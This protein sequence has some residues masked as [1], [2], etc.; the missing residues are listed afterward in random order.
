MKRRNFI[1][2]TAV[3][4][5][6]LM[7]NPLNALAFNNDFPV[8]RPALEKR[9]FTSKAIEDAISK[10][11]FSVKDA[12]QGWLF[13][14]CFPNTLDTTV[15]HKIIDGKPD[16]YV[17]TGDIDAMW[18]RDSC[19]QVWPYLSFADKDAKLA[20]LIAGVIN[21]QTRQVLIDP[22]ANAFYN[23]PTKEGEW[24]TDMTTMR[25]GIHERKWE[26]DSLCYTI[27]LAYGYWKKTGDIKP[28]DEQWK[29][30]IKSILQT[31][32][33]QQR[34]NDRGPYHF[35]RVTEK[36]TDTVPMEG[37]GFPLK[38]TGLINSTFRP[39][40]DA[41]IYGYLIP[42]NFFA[43]VSL[44]QAGEMV[45]SIL[46]DSQLQSELLDLANEVETA[47]KKHGI[48]KH[49]IFGDIYAFE[50][51]GFGNHNLMDDA[52]IPSLLALPYLN[53]VDTKDP[54]YQNTRRFC[55]SD[56]NPFYYK[57]DKFEGIGG[58]HVS[59]DQMIW[60]LSI[61]AR[62]LTSTSTEEI[63]L[64]LKMLKESHAG[65]GFMHETF[66][67]NNPKDFT[68]SWFAWANTIYGEFL[69]K[70]FKEHPK[71]LNS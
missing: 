21:R 48:Y 2:S 25:P 50:V 49:P 39:S 69:W 41:T 15:Y 40:D 44:K 24:K 27:R 63:K 31:F 29:L 34:K 42:S 5:A 71:L 38:P 19:A 28:F 18:L 13:E 66:E 56:S 11:K 53:A 3:L 22:Y 33:E 35:Q 14:N 23:D 4:G 37:Y 57:S 61:I 64:C 1:Q 67:K 65:T 7:Y 36:P 47:I 16:T 6:T 12:E 60:P 54:I 62:G 8:V 58:P 10:F 26:I 45:S 46:K 51:D 52:N 68:R 70:V 55:L 20:N 32:K 30:A 43:L 17:I 9:H 59:K